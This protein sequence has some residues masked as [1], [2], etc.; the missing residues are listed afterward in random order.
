M[1]IELINKDIKSFEIRDMEL[2]EISVSKTTE[3]T[4]LSSELE[5]K[6]K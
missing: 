4:K 5:K 3:I 2:R 6:T 1:T